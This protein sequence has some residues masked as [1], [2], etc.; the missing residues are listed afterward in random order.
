MEIKCPLATQAK[1]K[2]NNGYSGNVMVCRF[3]PLE[4]GLCIEEAWDILSDEKVLTSVM[5]RVEERKTQAKVHDCLLREVEIRP[6]SRGC[7][8]AN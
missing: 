5:A 8:S 4:D 2:Y 6:E 1:L 7:R 3:C